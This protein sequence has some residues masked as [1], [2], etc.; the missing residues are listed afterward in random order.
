M[1]FAAFSQVHG[2]L[3]AMSRDHLLYLLNAIQDLLLELA[4]EDIVLES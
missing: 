2:L 1:P 4:D 3:P